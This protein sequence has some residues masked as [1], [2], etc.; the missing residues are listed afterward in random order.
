MVAMHQ[1]SVSGPEPRKDTDKQMHSGS[2]HFQTR[3]R[4]PAQAGLLL[5]SASISSGNL[6]THQPWRFLRLGDYSYNMV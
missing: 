4:S 5:G 1:L 3:K 2:V 6:V